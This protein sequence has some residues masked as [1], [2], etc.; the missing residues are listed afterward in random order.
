[1]PACTAQ[2][3]CAAGS[4]L[5]LAA[6]RAPVLN[7][8]A[9]SSSRCHTKCPSC[10]KHSNPGHH[11]P[12]T[13]LSSRKSKVVDGDRLGRGCGP[14][15]GAG[16]Q[17]PRPQ[18]HIPSLR[19]GSW[20][21][22]A[23]DTRGSWSPQAWS[24]SS[25]PVLGDFP[26]LTSFTSPVSGQRVPEAAVA[27]PREEREGQDARRARWPCAGQRIASVSGSKPVNWAVTIA[28]SGPAHGGRGWG[29]GAA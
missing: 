14:S 4:G 9:C 15:H 21:A 2:V 29:R 18:D 3:G 7:L 24:P 20:P 22:R 13:R 16:L 5:G 19:K 1:M 10:S 27:S 11:D 17:G 6:F 12:S 26:M 28:A 25:S 23:G 8:C